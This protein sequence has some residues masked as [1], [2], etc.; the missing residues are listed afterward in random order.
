MLTSTDDAKQLSA[1]A[2]KE[3][4]FTPLKAPRL[5]PEL[6][7]VTVRFMAYKPTADR[8]PIQMRLVQLNRPQMVSAGIA[9]ACQGQIATP[10]QQA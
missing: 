2:A 10:H 6:T 5:D 8:P 3:R 4:S 7:V 1:Q 9:P